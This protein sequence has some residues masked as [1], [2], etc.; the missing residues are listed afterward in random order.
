MQYWFNGPENVPD[1][2]DA[3]SV[4]TFECLYTTLGGHPTIP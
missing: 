3:L 2:T 4:F 1:N